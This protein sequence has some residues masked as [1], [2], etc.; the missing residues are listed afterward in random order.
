MKIL[1]FGE[2]GQLASSLKKELFEFNVVQVGSQQVSF[3][4]FQSIR[5]CIRKHRPQIIINAAAYTAVDKAEIEHDIAK[6]INADAI[7]VIAEEARIVQSRVIHFST[8]YVFDGCKIDPYTEED[9]VKPINYY[10][11][12][13][14]QFKMSVF[15]YPGSVHSDARV[16]QRQII[17]RLSEWN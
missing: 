17:Q 10:Y 5:D 2:H 14:I 4:D 11:D 9:Q 3:L 13:R 8:D 15:P 1:I 12:K 6:T 7:K 16:E